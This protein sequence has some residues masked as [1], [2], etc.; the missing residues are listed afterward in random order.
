MT[1]PETIS[2]S[3][4]AAAPPSPEKRTEDPHEEEIPSKKPRLESV[5]RDDQDV[6]LEARLGGILCCAVCL[7][8][9]RCGVYQCSNGHLMC[10]G[11]FTHLLADARIRDE[12]A[13]CPN[14]R[15]EISR[16]LATRNLGEFYLYI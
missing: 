2:S 9:P 4:P 12:T 15:V 14:C 6:K 11:C 13:T 3:G 5:E 16:S 1:E 7:D 10:A 8:L